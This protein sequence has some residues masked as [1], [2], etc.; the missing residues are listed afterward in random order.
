MIDIRISPDSL[1]AWGATLGSRLA[2]LVTRS[3]AMGV[4]AGK[5]VTR[6]DAALVKR[7]A[8]ALQQHGIGANAGVILAPLAIEPAPALDEATR[9]RVADGLDRLSEALEASAT[10][11]TEWP[12]MRGVFG[13]D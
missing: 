5:P 11:S 2:D 12:V 9:Q 3:V 13:D 7:L 8:K 1:P 6:L 10:P 4:L